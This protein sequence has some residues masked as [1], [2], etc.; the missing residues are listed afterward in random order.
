MKN[1]VRGNPASAGLALAEIAIGVLLLF[2]PIAFTRGIIIVLG[3]VLAVLGVMSIARYFRAYP[4][5]AAREQGL[6]RGLGMLLVGGFCA[7]NAD[8]FIRTF[9]VLTMLY[10]VLLLF[11]ALYK[12]QKA[13]DILRLKIGGAFWTGLSAA[14]TLLFAI[15]ILLNPFATVSALWMFIGIILIGEAVLDIAALALG[16]K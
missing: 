7:F 15:V 1:I 6:A 9:P 13:V 8:W 11:S 12:V 16:Q 10:G 2:K 4:V 3:V 5:E 14:T